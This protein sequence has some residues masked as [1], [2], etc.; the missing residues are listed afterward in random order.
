MWIDNKI[1][2]TDLARLEGC[3]FI[4][5]EKLQNKTILVTG[6]TGL[7]GYNLI[8]GLIYVNRK[9]NLNLHILALVRDIV[10][11][12][13]KYKEQLKD[14]DSLSFIL[15]E[16]EHLPE[17]QERVDY[18]VHSASPTESAYF[19]THPVE[20]IKTAIVGTLSILELAKHKEVLGMVYLSSMEVYGSIKE[21]NPLSEEDL[22]YLNPLSIRNCYPES[23]RQCEALCAAYTSE[24]NVPAMSIRLAQ[25]FG[26]GVNRNDGR[27][28]AE[29]ARCIMEEKDIELLTD[30]S[31]KRCYL[32]TMDAV[33]AILT[34]LLKGQFGQVYNAANPET[35]CSVK[36]MAE[37]VAGK[38]GNGKVKVKVIDGQADIQKFSSTHFYDLKITKIEDIGWK[39]NLNLV[40]MYEN[41]IGTVL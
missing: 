22:G 23:K 20:T 7:I 40:Q 38:F 3:N 36:E 14:N 24:Y 17:I 41:M 10:D 9:K 1:F 30:G 4:P 11:A 35:Y 12:K 19:I 37:M 6:A 5:W 34:V 32:Y 15:G 29:F 21:E 2:N 27:V 16:V 31:S 26:P 39:P 25:T 33:S 18:I 8:S 28:F 13:E